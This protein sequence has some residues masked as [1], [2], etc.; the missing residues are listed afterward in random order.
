MSIK[1]YIL[2]T[3]SG[4]KIRLNSA[5]SFKPVF[6]LA[7]FISRREAKSEMWLVEEEIRREKVGS[8]PT[9]Y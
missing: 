6:Y 7:N 5:R 9:F 3:L 1:I 8:L 2:S 4:T